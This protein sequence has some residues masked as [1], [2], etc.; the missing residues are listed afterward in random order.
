M[1]LNQILLVFK[2]HFTFLLGRAKKNSL[3]AIFA[4]LPR[5]QFLLLPLLPFDKLLP[6][7][8]NREDSILYT[9][10]Y[11]NVHWGDSGF[12]YLGCNKK[13]NTV[14]KSFI[15]ELGSRGPA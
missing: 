14:G 15:K 6:S 4:P 2:F 12:S 9:I 1:R 7:S 8:G 3:I 10:D 13:M 5:V 11:R